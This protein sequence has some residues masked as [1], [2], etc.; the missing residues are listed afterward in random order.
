MGYDDLKVIECADLLATVAGG[1]GA[2]LAATVEDAVVA[3]DVMTA[4]K[5]SAETRAWCRPGDPAAATQ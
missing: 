2:G 3:A 5:A 4:L 1:S